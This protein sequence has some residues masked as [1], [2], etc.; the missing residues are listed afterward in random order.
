MLLESLLH[1]VATKLGLKTEAAYSKLESQSTA[2]ELQRGC[3]LPPKLVKAV[4][5]SLAILST[6]VVS[7]R[8]STH[9]IRT[10]YTRVVPS[11]SAAQAPRS[12]L[13]VF[14]P[15][16]KP[17]P[18]LCKAIVS[19][20]VL[21]YPSPTIINWDQDFND[22][23]FVE[24]GSHLAKIKGTA[25]HLNSLDETHDDDLV[26]M[27][28]GY[29]A[30]IQ[31]RPQ[32]LVDRYY[33]INRRAVERIASEFGNSSIEDLEI[34]QQIIFGCQ[35]RCWPWGENDPPCYAVPESTL[36]ADIYGPETDTDVDDE[37]NPYI[38][39]RQRFL[40][41]G[42]AIGTVG[43]M[44]KLFQQAL[45]QAPQDANFG[46]DQYILSHIFGDQELYREI[47]RRDAGEP[48]R[49]G[50]NEGHIEEVRAKAAA[51]P[52]G[53]FEFGIGIDYGSEIGLNTVF[54]EDDTD[55]IK[56]A[57]QDHLEK[58][59]NDR[60]IFGESKRLQDVPSDISSTTQ[61]FR[62]SSNASNLPDDVSWDDV[63]LFTD[64]WTG[65]SPV[66]IHHNAH[67]DGMKSLR[68]TWWPK[69]WF[70]EHL[71][72]ML[73]ASARGP[74]GSVA[75]EYIDGQKGR[76][77]WPEEMWKGGAQKGNVAKVGGSGK[78]LTYQGICGGYDE[79]LFRD[80]RGWI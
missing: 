63:S 64:V 29:D 22:P 10:T 37:A 39:Y 47:V 65:I 45:A 79:E 17:D 59:Q 21:G 78:W 24:G 9:K 18:N 68:E 14:I 43:A 32:T 23:A 15:A 70:Q 42:V 60:G 27:V 34:S 54:A 3:Q 55:W 25:E 30:W 75:A 48:P 19:G 77:Y 2:H 69:I 44:R 35:K 5:V 52:D 53:N 12:N 20:N 40:N 57:D 72:A 80:G 7:F 31:L 33:E 4:V 66:V 6:L 28:D 50:W 8:S 74:A 16:S 49:E 11:N 41:S 36:P 46:S 26:L 62:T 38:K 56:Y 51:H 1:P 67:R 76:E 13:H 58:I 71:R 61:P 73:N